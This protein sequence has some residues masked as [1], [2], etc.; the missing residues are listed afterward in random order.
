MA[1]GQ[2]AKVVSSIKDFLKKNKTLME[3]RTVYD[4]SWL[5]G[6][7]TKELKKQMKKDLEN[8]MGYII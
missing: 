6:N 4:K 3:T 1:V 8:G 2:P 7:I 5:I